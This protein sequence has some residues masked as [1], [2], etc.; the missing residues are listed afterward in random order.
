MTG[1]SWI[2][3]PRIF[4]HLKGESQVY[5]FEGNFSDYEENK[6]KRL[7]DQAPKRINYKK[8]IE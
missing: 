5:W 4:W 3:S 6:K 7:G 2:V 8:L 1:G